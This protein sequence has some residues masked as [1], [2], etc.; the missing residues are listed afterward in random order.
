MSGHRS[1]RIITILRH[2]DWATRLPDDLPVIEQ[3]RLV[4]HPGRPCLLSGLI[5]GAPAADFVIALTGGAG[6]V[7]RLSTAWI[8]LGTPSGDASAVDE[9]AVLQ[10]A[11]CWARSRRRRA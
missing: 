6:G 7:A 2:A 5:D 8:K 9:D 11:A 10:R 1:T 4:D 3:W